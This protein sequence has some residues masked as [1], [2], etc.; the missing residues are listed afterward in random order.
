MFDP[1]S[2][3]FGMD[4]FRV[5]SVTTLGERADVRV[6]IETTTADHGCPGCGVMSSRVKERPTRQVRDL[7]ASGQRVELW[8]RAR[9]LVC[10]EA[11]CGRHS[12]V[13]R[14][15]QIRLRSRLTG[16]FQDHLARSVAVSNRAVLEVGREHGVGW[17]T[18]HRAL[19]R[20]ADRWLP[21]PPVVT[22]LGIDETRARSVRWVNADGVWTRSNPWLTRSST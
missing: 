17:N 4:S 13:E 10:R 19:V 2:L 15:D 18:I 7:T 11:A 9:R 22:V 16:R 5:V 14:S 12:F 1:T 21:T 20:A 8:W 3:L 6:V